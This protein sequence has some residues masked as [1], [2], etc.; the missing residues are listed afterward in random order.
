MTRAESAWR[1]RG[2]RDGYR[3]RKYQAAAAARMGGEKAEL[4]YSDGY[5]IGV[6]ERRREREGMTA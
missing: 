5:R 3:D 2:F 4:W 6:R 1:E